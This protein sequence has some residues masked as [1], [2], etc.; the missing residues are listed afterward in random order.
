MTTDH[1]AIVTGANHGIGAATARALA[2]RGCAALCSY[3]RVIDPDE[4]GFPQAYRDNRKSNAGSVLGS[5]ISA[6]G[7][8]I[9]MGWVTDAVR[10][11]V[12]ASPTLVHVAAP[13]EVADVI[14]CLA[15]DAARPHHRQH[16]R[17]PLT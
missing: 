10:D 11:M 12:A 16:H 17:P 1:V 7:R 9:A 6:G 5:I 15:S 4:P 13:D 8:A 14:A 2:R 3:I